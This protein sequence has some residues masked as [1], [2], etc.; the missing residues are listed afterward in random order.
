MML[1]HGLDYGLLHEQVGEL[2]DDDALQLA[3]LYECGLAAAYLVE[4]GHG[5]NDELLVVDSDQA[6]GVGHSQQ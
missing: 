1:W 4:H 3:D 5:L 2:G 6:G